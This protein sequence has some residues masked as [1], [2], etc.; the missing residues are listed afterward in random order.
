MTD[1]I[2]DA[3]EDETREYRLAQNAHDRGCCTPLPKGGLVPR[4]F[5]G[6]DCP[7]EYTADVVYID[8]LTGR[9]VLRYDGA[10]PAN[11]NPYYGATPDSE[12]FRK[13]G[14]DIGAMIEPDRAVISIEECRDRMRQND[15]DYWD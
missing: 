8:R 2:D 10:D 15:D 7:D 1:S 3:L 4:F 12:C 11:T 5:K 9:E 13:K 14:L 6:W